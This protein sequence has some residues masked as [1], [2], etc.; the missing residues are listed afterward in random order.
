MKTEVIDN[1]NFMF[2]IGS[3]P[4]TVGIG[5]R[6]FLKQFNVAKDKQEKLPAVLMDMKNCKMNDFLS[7]SSSKWVTL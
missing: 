5:L 6:D 1:Y 2:I 4:G 3:V 7:S